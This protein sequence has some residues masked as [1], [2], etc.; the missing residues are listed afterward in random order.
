MVSK[1]MVVAT[2]WVSH[3]IKQVGL[4]FG[5]VMLMLHNSAP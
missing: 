3:L 1:Q 2:Q 5:W 4:F